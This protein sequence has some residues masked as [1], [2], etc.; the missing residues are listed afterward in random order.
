MGETRIRRVVA[1]LA[2]V[3]LLTASFAAATPGAAQSPA[4]PTIVA[5]MTYADPVNGGPPDWIWANGM[6]AGEAIHLELDFE[7]DG[8]VD[9]S[10]DSVANG[11]G[12]WAYDDIG[13]AGRLL[14]GSHITLTGTDPDPDW[15]KDL[16]VQPVRVE[17]ADPYSDGAGGVAYPGATVHLT[18]PLPGGGGPD[19]VSEDLTAD[20]NGW[21][22]YDLAAVGF[23]LGFEHTVSASLDD[24][25]GDLSSHGIDARRPVVHS[26]IGAGPGGYLRLNG[27]PDGMPV[28]IEVDFDNDGTVDE[29]I[30]ET[31]YMFGPGVVF[32]GDFGQLQFGSRVTV[33]AVNGEAPFRW[34]KVLD[35]EP[36]SVDGWSAESD[37]VEGTAPPERALTVEVQADGPSP[38]TVD[39]SSD[40]EGH[41]VAGF[42]GMWDVQPGTGFLVHLLDPDGD[43]TGI[44][45]TADY[46]VTLDAWPTA[47][48]WD[49]APVEVLVGNLSPN[50][51][52]FLTVNVASDP[53]NQ[54]TWLPGI[55]IGD[56]GFGQ[57]TVNVP[58]FVGAFD[59]A[60]AP[61]ACILV[62]A[63]Q[64]DP[65]GRNASVPLSF[66]RIDLFRFTLNEPENPF[67]GGTVGD[68]ITS[69][70]QVAHDEWIWVQGTGFEPGRGYELDQCKEVYF[71]TEVCRTTWSS[72]AFTE[73]D[74]N[75]SFGV[76]LQV[77]RNVFGAWG[78]DLQ[79][80][81][82]Q[83]F[84]LRDGQTVVVNATGLPLEE[85]LADCGAG[86]C[87]VGARPSGGW[88]ADWTPYRSE[89]LTFSGDPVP[90]SVHVAQSL[91]QQMEGIVHIV[92]AID[93]EREVSWDPW[94]GTLAYP[95]T[96]VD[97]WLEPD[98]TWGPWSPLPDPDDLGFYDCADTLDFD[99]TSGAQE[100][101]HCAF[102]LEVREG[103]ELWNGTFFGWADAQFAGFDLTAAVTSATPSAKPAGVTIRGEVTCTGFM[104]EQYLVTVE[105]TIAQTGTKGKQPST[106]TGS[107]ATTVVCSGTMANAGKAI[108][109]A[110]VPVRFKAG[111]A[112]V[113]ID[114]SSAGFT[115]IGA[116]LHVPSTVTIE[117]PPRGKG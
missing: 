57:T 21:W 117:S 58:R 79:I 67:A 13:T 37:W 31:A 7:D 14:P 61:G 38:A 103:T 75:G 30:P 48:L 1:G 46:P 83:S 88:D 62:T 77:G 24:G 9:Y 32:S 80:W 56:G 86:E 102:S 92:P 74:E 17:F 27:W 76:P 41:W 91:V 111:E 53:F 59:C 34:Q 71:G 52:A 15:V 66:G 65:F 70:D 35:L 54:V 19:L 11:F 18:V 96:A 98:L 50:S 90:I 10:K 2:G 105:G 60:S 95:F 28:T 112:T 85:W 3:A 69:L 25:D 82:D 5:S 47:G 45:F 94:T 97:R 116:P 51:V 55:P 68:P 100:P 29:T 115:R 22:H 33:T 72:R 63:D 26:T 109:T 106:I 114:V 78:T 8:T 44:Q 107:F 12:Q 43:T 39:T 36:M 104:P 99:P 81:L 20:S 87:W 16:V 49:G 110:F 4:G 6:T 101:V 64:N 23:D 93:S 42:A 40:T 108:W 89:P 84:D 113:T 73:A